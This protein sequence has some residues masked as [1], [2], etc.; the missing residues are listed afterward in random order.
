MPK[1]LYSN[2][3]CEPVYVR[4]QFPSQ[5]SFRTM[6]LPHAPSLSFNSPNVLLLGTL[7][8]NVL[9]EHL[10]GPPLVVEVHD[11]DIKLELEATSKAL[12]GLESQD[13]LIGTHAYSSNLAHGRIYNSPYG[14]ANIDLGILLSGQLSMELTIP[15]VKGPRANPEA[16]PVKSDALVRMKSE[17]VHPGDYLESGCELTVR[18]EL[19]HPLSFLNAHKVPVIHEKPPKIM[20]PWRRQ[21]RKSI[22]KTESQLAVAPCPFNRLVYVVSA[23]GMD[24]VERLLARINEINAKTL[25]LDRL[26]PSVQKAA[27]STY[28]LTQ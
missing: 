11:R 12:F 20:S 5:P 4:Y 25:G 19:S 28:K 10:R 14:T 7:N 15:V 23:D 17:Q 21:V 9:L 24:L 6:G 2:S 8:Q 26:S 3:R 1:F 13:D 22:P 16:S 27:L 18:L